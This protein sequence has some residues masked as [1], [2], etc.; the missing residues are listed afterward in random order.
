MSEYFDLGDYSMKVTT[1]SA[2][3]QT[4]FDRGLAWCYG[5]NHD[6]AIACFR[7]ALEADSALAMAHWGIAYAA[8]PNYNKPWEMFD[9]EDLAKCH[10]ITRAEIEKALAAA[11]SASALERALIHA[12]EARCPATPPEDLATLNDAYALAMR[13]VYSAFPGNPDVATFYAESMMNRTTWKLWDLKTGKHAE[14]AD[15]ARIVEVLERGLADNERTGRKPHAGL[16]HMY[17]HAME[18]SPHPEKAIRACDQLRGLVPDSGHLQ[19]MP[20]HIDVLCGNYQSVVDWN[21]N[22]IVADNKFLAREGPLNFYSFYRCH[23]YHFKAYGGMFLGRFALAMEAADE[24]VRSLPDEL[25]RVQSPPMADWLEAFVPTDYHVLIRFGKWEEI[26]AKPLPEDQHLYAFTTATAHYAKA[27]AAAA[28]NKLDIADKQAILFE[29]AFERVP[30]TRKLMNNFCRDILCVAREMMKGEIAYRRGQYD[31]AFAHLR[32]SVEL[33]DN[34]PYDEPWGWMQPTRHALGALLLERNHVEEAASVY[35]AD[36]GFDTTLSRACQHPD[37][38]WALHGYH[39]CLT[40]L[41]RIEE[42]NIIKQRLDLARART[43][44]PVKASCF[45]KQGARAAA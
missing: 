26:L 39:E 10:A 11:P 36:L 29:A 16:L 19:H 3:A 20:T 43:D 6:E 40:K 13:N 1:G 38:V 23:D 42:A 31:E 4:W 24:M 33:D 8:G 15:T 44:V 22:A 9:P 5:F 45:C 12:L 2:E 18:M 17:I 27:V 14:G 41:G 35:R 34:L 30:E 37:N 28:S 7:K 32:K 25:M 21:S